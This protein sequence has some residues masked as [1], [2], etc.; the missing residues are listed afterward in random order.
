MCIDHCSGIPELV[1]TEI[2]FLRN[3]ERICTPTCQYFRRRYRWHL[4]DKCL[5]VWNINLSSTEY[6]ELKHTYNL[7]RFK[8]TF[9]TISG[10]A[11]VAN[12]LVLHIIFNPFARGV[13]VATVFSV[14][15]HCFENNKQT[16]ITKH[17]YYNIEM[18]ITNIGLRAV[19]TPS[20]P[21][22]R[23]ISCDDK[24]ELREMTEPNHSP[25]RTCNATSCRRHVILF[26]KRPKLL[27]TYIIYLYICTVY[28][29]LN[30]CIR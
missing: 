11:F 29:S 16:I 12:A 24:S 14:T 5:S 3:P 19:V 1:H 13:L 17:N 27:E 25:K 9:V 8:D 18:L 23:G 15:R 21:V 20:D 10:I 28:A 26:N 30:L 2:H 6:F 7:A 4:G 22:F